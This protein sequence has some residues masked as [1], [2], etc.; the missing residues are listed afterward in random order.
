MVQKEPGAGERQVD[1]VLLTD[2]AVEKRLNQA[3]AK[4]ERLPT[5][6]GKVTR[7]RLEPLL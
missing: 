3:I 7:I 6:I 2:R 1:I 5:V 4:I